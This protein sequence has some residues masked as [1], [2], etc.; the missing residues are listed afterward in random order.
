M[1][2]IFSVFVKFVFACWLLQE[3]ATMFRC[4]QNNNLQFSCYLSNNLSKR[5]LKSEDQM[6]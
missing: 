4:V 5:C 6:F 3:L 2:N 1:L